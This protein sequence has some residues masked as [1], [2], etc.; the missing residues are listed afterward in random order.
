[1]DQDYEDCLGRDKSPSDMV[2]YGFMQNINK[3][4]PLLSPKFN[5]PSYLDLYRGYVK[6]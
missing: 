3:N 2:K 6:K 5:T 4:Y 1:M